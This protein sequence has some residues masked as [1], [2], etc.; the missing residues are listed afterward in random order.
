MQQTELTRY[1][2]WAVWNN[3]NSKRIYFVAR[4]NAAD[5]YGFTLSLRDSRYR[6]RRFATHKAAQLAAKKHAIAI[7]EP[8]WDE[9]KNIAV[10]MRLNN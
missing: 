3:S 5:E 4:D 6:L 2:V 9:Q 8:Y 10:P 7:G 1:D